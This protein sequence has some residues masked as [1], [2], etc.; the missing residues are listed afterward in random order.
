MFATLTFLKSKKRLCK[1]I[2][3]EEKHIGD[4]EYLNVVCF[5]KINKKKIEKKLKNKVDTIILAEN[6]N[7]I[8][9]ENIKVYNS[10]KYLK[11]I[12]IYTFKNIIRLSNIPLNKLSVCL[13]DKKGLFADFAYSLANSASIIKIVTDKPEFFIEIKNKIYDDFGM[14]P[15]ITNEMSD[16]DLG[17]DLSDSIPKIWFKTPKNFVTIDKSCVALGAGLKKYVPKGINQC[18]FAGVLQKYK[19]FRRLK[20]LNAQVMI[21]NNGIY[22]I[23]RDN[24]KNFLDN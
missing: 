17:L 11:I 22:K 8:E 10:D 21:K 23:N 9:F 16:A 5:K 4:I 2:R 20:L 24:I 14:E 6:I 19:D 12:S 3:I 18:D 7:N 1:N 15:I 13:I